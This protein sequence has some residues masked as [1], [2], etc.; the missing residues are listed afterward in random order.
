MLRWQFNYVHLDGDGILTGDK[1]N[2]AG[3]E[4]VDHEDMFGLRMIF[5]F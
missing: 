3:T 1:N 4:R 2:E 5:K